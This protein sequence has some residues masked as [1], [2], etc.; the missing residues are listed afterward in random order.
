LHRQKVATHCGL[1]ECKLTHRQPRS[2]A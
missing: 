1:V 2:F